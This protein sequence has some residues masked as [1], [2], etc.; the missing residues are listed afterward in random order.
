MINEKIA[1]AP[2]MNVLKR[3]TETTNGFSLCDNCFWHRKNCVL[4]LDESSNKC[5]AHTVRENIPLMFDTNAAL[6]LL[7]L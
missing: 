4:H 1:N 5:N 2:D 7:V 3:N 6:M